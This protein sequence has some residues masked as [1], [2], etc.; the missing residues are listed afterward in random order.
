MSEIWTVQRLLEWTTDFLK[1]HARQ[2]ARLEA[3]I[4][5]SSA[6][7]CRRI[8]LY[9]G[10]DSEPTESQRTLFREYVKRRAGGEPVA[11]LVGHKE[12]FSLSF[13][14]NRSTLIPRPETEQLV[15]E[16]LDWVK[17]RENSKNTEKKLISICDVGTGSGAIAVAIAKNTQNTQITATDISSEALRIAKKNAEKHEVSDRVEFIES[18]LLEN[19]QGL[20]ELIVS[21]P[22]Y[23][24][25]EEYEQLDGDVKDFEPRGALLAGETGREIIEKL[26]PQA[27]CKLL[28]GGKILIELSP[29]IADSTAEL[30]SPESWSE[31]RILKDFAGLKRILSAVKT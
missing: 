26:L 10:F 12:F 23:V 30:F 2:S 15:L 6:L 16:S 7:S 14:V 20:F 29:M 28:P 19:V 9:T 22:P 25:R 11:Y 1:K 24:S 5:L 8:E 17:I 18:D 31:V 4:L 27:L 13:E 21:N 3:E